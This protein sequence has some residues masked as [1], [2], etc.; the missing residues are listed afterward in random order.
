MLQY[1]QNYYNSPAAVY[2]FLVNYKD[3]RNRLRRLFYASDCQHLNSFVQPLFNGKFFQEP[4]LG[5]VIQR[6]LLY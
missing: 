2:P 3:E 4:E 1:D 6:P 5:V